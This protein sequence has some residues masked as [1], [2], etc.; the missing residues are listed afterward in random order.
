MKHIYTLFIIIITLASCTERKEKITLVQNQSSDYTI[1]VSE[2]ADSLTQSAAHELRT[3]IF[4]VSG[5]NLKIANG[6]GKSNKLIIIGKELLND[7]MLVELD[8]I[9][10][11]GFIIRANDGNI[12]ISGNEGKTNLY[13]TYTFI[14]EFL[15]CRLLSSTEEYVPR[16]KTID[17]PEINKT[18]E[19]A[20]S[21]R[22]TLFPGQKSAK[23][24]Y[25]HKIETL[26]EWGS[27]VHTF[28]KLIP[29]GQYFEN[30]P[31]YFSLNVR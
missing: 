3:Y 6:I 17:I 16:N 27:F 4:K 20:F 30:H 24:R 29:P 22:R 25:W 19:P 5:A 11:D 8:S 2:S 23:Y 18:Y 31:E 28:N 14:D 12:I 1:I 21:F 9:K 26:D 13:A 7:S 10:E 15:G